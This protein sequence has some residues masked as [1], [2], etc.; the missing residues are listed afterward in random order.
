MDMLVYDK[1]GAR[2]SCLAREVLVT[3]DVQKQ[4][5]WSYRIRAAGKPPDLVGEFGSASTS[6]GAAGEK[7]ERHQGGACRN[8]GCTPPTGAQPAPAMP[9][10]GGRA[11]QAAATEVSERQ[12]AGGEESA[13]GIGT[14]LGRALVAPLGCG[15]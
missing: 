12:L 1:R 13:L 7:R 15:G 5:G 4:A 11:F 9:P 2:T 3:F 10:V 14:A 6:K 8:S